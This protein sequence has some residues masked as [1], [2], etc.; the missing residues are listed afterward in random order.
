MEAMA[1][2]VTV[3]VA[4][5]MTKYTNKYKLY[6]FSPLCRYEN[7][8][9]SKLLPFP[10]CTVNRVVN[11]ADLMIGLLVMTRRSLL[12]IK[13][14]VIR[15]YI[16][17]LQPKNAEHRKTVRISHIFMGE[18]YVGMSVSLSGWWA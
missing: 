16:Y 15:F 9:P 8:C 4:S 2:A 12:E 11:R 17:H 13:Y 5:A 6:L 18:G 3:A 14:F 1:V 7:L 10:C